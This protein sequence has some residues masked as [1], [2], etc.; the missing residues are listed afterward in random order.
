MAL[1]PIWRT[2]VVLGPGKLRGCHVVVPQVKLIM[3]GFTKWECVIVSGLESWPLSTDKISMKLDDQMHGNATSRRQASYSIGSIDM[4]VL[5]RKNPTW[6]DLSI[7]IETR[8]SVVQQCS[9]LRK[10]SRDRSVEVFWLSRKKPS[11]PQSLDL[12]NL[13]LCL[14]RARGW[15]GGL[16]KTQ[17]G[18]INWRTYSLLGNR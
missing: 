17:R 10:A 4:A 13:W 12:Q 18:K 9:E 15:I 11:E 7:N 6:S 3:M 1:H 8:F 14:A 16:G 2:F 5:H